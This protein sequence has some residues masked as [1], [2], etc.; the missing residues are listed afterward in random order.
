MVPPDD[1]VAEM[2]PLWVRYVRVA[3]VTLGT[4]F[5]PKERLVELTWGANGVL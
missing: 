4:Q 5:T 1:T 2:P 3:F